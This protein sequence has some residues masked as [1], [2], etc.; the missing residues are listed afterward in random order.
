MYEGRKVY[1]V[2]SGRTRAR[3]PRRSAFL[4]AVV[5]DG[6][7]DHPS[8]RYRAQR[9]R[10][11][12]PRNIR[13]RRLTR[14]NYPIFDG[15][16]VRR[17]EESKEILPDGFSSSRPYF[18]R[19]CAEVRTCLLAY[20]DIPPSSHLSWPPAEAYFPRIKI[21]GAFSR[22]SAHEAR[23]HIAGTFPT[24]HRELVESHKAL[25]FPTFIAIPWRGITF[26]YPSSP[27]VLLSVHLREPSSTA[28]LAAK[29]S[30]LVLTRA[31]GSLVPLE[32]S[33]A[34]A[35]YGISGDVCWL[36]VSDDGAA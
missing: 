22:T 15:W 5:A 33:A 28:A 32:E 1:A 19:P 10:T 31:Q 16:D 7:R 18:S 11:T 20:R 12:F 9:T 23:R 24:K 3:L 17:A 4:I 29:I 34:E 27:T 30:R 13:L 26:P 36:L 25:N 14:M 8:P 6:P 35:L 2:A 21:N